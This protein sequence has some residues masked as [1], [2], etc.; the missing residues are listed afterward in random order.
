MQIHLADAALSRG[1][2]TLNDAVVSGPLSLG[3]RLA[4][5]A[6]LAS[7]E[8]AALRRASNWW[9]NAVVGRIV[10]LL[11]GAR[12]RVRGLEHIERLAPTGGVLLA[13]NHRTFF[14]LFAVTYAFR[15]QTSSCGEVYF[16]VRSRFWY[17]HPL[18]PWLNA[19]GAG[20]RMFPPVFRA[21][22]QRDVTRRGLDW[23]AE[24][25]KEPGVV[26]GMHP[27]GTRS[28]D[29]DP[30]TLLP[31]EQSFGRVALLSRA[32]IVPVFVNGLSDSLWEESRRRK[33][34]DA[35]VNVA[36]GAP[37]S[38]TEFDG[39]DPSR[40]RNQLAIGRRVLQAVQELAQEVRSLS[41]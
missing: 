35:I 29:P 8:N 18:G 37:V 23:L 6:A 2:E 1:V 3:E 34:T 4:L 7:N 22:H 16:P 17:D 24:R 33:Q 39:C 31:P 30:F 11:C 21:A 27:E 9:A 26:V 14:D 19:V 5:A 32:T 25:L 15:G 41:G 40:L 20:M 13:P 36:F 38:T 12:L 10:A 28:R